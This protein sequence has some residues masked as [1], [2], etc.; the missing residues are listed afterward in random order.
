MSAEINGIFEVIHKNDVEENT[1]KNFFIESN[2][3]N[4]KIKF[5]NSPSIPVLVQSHHR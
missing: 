5:H 3:Y 2:L 1:I 4:L